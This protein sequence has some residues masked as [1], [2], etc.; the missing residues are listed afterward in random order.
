MRYQTSR[1]CGNGFMVTGVVIILL[2]FL[3]LLLS[4]TKTIPTFDLLPACSVLMLF[5][6]AIIWLAGANLS[7]KECVSERY[8]LLRYKSSESG[9]HRR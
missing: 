6:G 5:V 3:L 8:Y 4:Q 9:Q 7:G 2:G 1:R